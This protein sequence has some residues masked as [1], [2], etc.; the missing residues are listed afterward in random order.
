MQ[1]NNIREHQK[2]KKNSNK[3]LENFKIKIQFLNAFSD[4]KTMTSK[5]NKQLSFS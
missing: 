4:R 5:D 3:N 2:I 1:K